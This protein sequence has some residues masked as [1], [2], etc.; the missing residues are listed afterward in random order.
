MLGGFDMHQGSEA[1]ILQELVRILEDAWESGSPVAGQSPQDRSEVARIA[2][3]RM[4]SFSRRKVPDHDRALQVRD[5]ARGLVARFEKHPELV[6]PLVVDYRDIAEKL[7]DGYA[8]A[9]QHR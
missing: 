3:R 1:A 2:L 9:Q 5:V 7:L 6:G 4:A 8:N